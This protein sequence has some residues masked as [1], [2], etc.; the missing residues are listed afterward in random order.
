[1]ISYT[2]R[3]PIG[4]WSNDGHGQCDYYH[5]KSNKPIKNV[6][7]AFLAAKKKYPD[8]S[9]DIFCY[10]YQDSKVP[11]DI[12]KKIK[13]L[14]F[15]LTLSEGGLYD[16]EEFACYVAFFCMLGDI[17]LKLTQMPTPE[18]LCI[19]CFGYGLFGN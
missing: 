9:P 11:E 2:I 5:F 13:A 1:M 16:V 17:E 3:I 8:I 18:S 14:G 15:S 6:E 10:K 4:D 19:S 12:S 7:K